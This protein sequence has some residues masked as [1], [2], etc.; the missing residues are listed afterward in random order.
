MTENQYSTPAD[1]F[2]WASS[3]IGRANTMA[4]AFSLEAAATGLLLY[5]RQHPYPFAASAQ[6]AGSDLTRGSYNKR[7]HEQVIGGYPIWWMLLCTIRSSLKPSKGVFL[8]L[9]SA[10]RLRCRRPASEA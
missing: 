2:G 5:S 7:P 4:I 8:C 10:S 6:I 3:R 1:I 9:T